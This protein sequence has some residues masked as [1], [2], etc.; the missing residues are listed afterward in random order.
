MRT[1]N[2]GVMF[3]EVV[4]NLF[5]IYVIYLLTYLRVFFNLLKLIIQN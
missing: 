5:G 4:N 1:G 3:F 2:F